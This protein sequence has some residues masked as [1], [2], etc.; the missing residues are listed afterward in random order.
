[1]KHDLTQNNPRSVD[2]Q[3]LGANYKW[4]TEGGNITKTEIKWRHMG[5]SWHRGI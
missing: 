2:Q 5:V 4:E 1:M 3:G